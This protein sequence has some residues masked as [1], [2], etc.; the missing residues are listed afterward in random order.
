MDY[1]D[2][3]EIDD[4]DQPV[5][6]VDEAPLVVARRRWSTG[7]IVMPMNSAALTTR[8]ASSAELV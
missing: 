8:W 4:G 3:D 2:D 1:P 7:G 6:R 5:E